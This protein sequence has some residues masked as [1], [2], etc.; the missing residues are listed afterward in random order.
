MNCN[1]MIFDARSDTELNSF[2]NLLNTLLSYNMSKDSDQYNDIHI[3]QEESLIVLEWVQTPYSKEYGAEFK[4]IDEDEVV[5]KDIS[6]PDGT[7]SFV[8]N[9]FEKE[10]QYANW[11]KEHPS[12]KFGINGWADMK[13]VVMKADDI[14]EE[15]DY[16]SA[17]AS[18]DRQLQ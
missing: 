17:E 8:A 12:W 13:D 16:I 2:H 15:D 14:D 9:D 6:L 5:L 3:Y 1:K 7:H 10:Y 18:N 4:L 11:I